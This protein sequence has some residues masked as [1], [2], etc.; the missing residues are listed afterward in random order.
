ME[1]QADARGLSDRPSTPQSNGKWLCQRSRTLRSDERFIKYRPHADN[2]IVP[3]D[4]GTVYRKK[5]AS[6][7]FPDGESPGPHNR[8]GNEIGCSGQ[9]EAA[10]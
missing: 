7:V 9:T 4:S 2:A 8:I 6:D 3:L 10:D 5:T 1:K